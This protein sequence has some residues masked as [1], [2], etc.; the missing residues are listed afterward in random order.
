[1]QKSLLY[2][3][4]IIYV[5]IFTGCENTSKS[6]SCLSG[7][8]KG[9]VIEA[10]VSSPFVFCSDGNKKGNSWITSDGLKP[11]FEEYYIRGIKYTRTFVYA[12]FKN[13]VN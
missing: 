11:I 9:I 12:E 1:M 5:M 3:M 8:F 10:E 13:S 7:G 4:L 6:M 2:I